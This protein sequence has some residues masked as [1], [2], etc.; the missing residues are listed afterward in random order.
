MEVSTFNAHEVGFASKNGNVVA[1]IDPIGCSLE[2]TL[3]LLNHSCDPNVIRVNNGRDT[4]MFA[5]RNIAEG[6]EIFDTYHSMGFQATRSQRQL[7][8]MG[9]YKFEC[10]CRPCVENWPLGK[11]TC[12]HNL[13]SIILKDSYYFRHAKES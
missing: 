9:K 5:C 10:Q 1:S 6:E 3:V 8:L 13:N 11:G 4:L 12:N 2:P 7:D